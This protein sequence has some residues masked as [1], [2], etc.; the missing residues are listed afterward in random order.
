MQPKSGNTTIEIVYWCWRF[1]YNGS[2]EWSNAE[3]C[4]FAWVGCKVTLVFAQKPPARQQTNPIFAA[5]LAQTAWFPLEI[6]S[7]HEYKLISSFNLHSWP[8]GPI[9]TIRIIVRVNE[10]IMVAVDTSRKRRTSVLYIQHL[11]FCSKGRPPQLRISIL[12]Y[13]TEKHNKAN[14]SKY[15]P[16]SDWLKPH[17]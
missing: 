6:S 11:I 9:R 10:K 8:Y 7:T 3:Y 16:V 12:I 1:K 5:Y 2:L 15:F 17:V 14:Y 4:L 13:R